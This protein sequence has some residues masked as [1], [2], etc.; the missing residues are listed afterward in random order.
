MLSTNENISRA[1]ISKIPPAA[2]LTLTPA[3]PLVGEDGPPDVFPVAEWVAV[4]AGLV[5]LVWCV[6]SAG[7]TVLVGEEDMAVDEDMVA[8]QEETAADEPATQ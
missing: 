4:D 3:F 5:E 8:G 6:D 1:R 7:G 2:T